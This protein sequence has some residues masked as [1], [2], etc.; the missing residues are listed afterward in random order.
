MKTRWINNSL[1]PQTPEVCLCLSEEEFRKAMRQRDIKLP[2]NWIGGA[3]S[4]ATTHTLEHSNTGQ[5]CAIVCLNDEGDLDAQQIAALLVHEAVHIW[6]N[7]SASY[8]E[9]QPGKEQEAYAIQSLSQ[10]LF[11]E[12]ARRKK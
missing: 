4:Q 2:G 6:Q 3:S 7:W 9:E 10:T 1:T 12:Y 8:G 5:V 11:T